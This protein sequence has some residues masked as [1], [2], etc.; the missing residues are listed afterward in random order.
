MTSINKNLWTFLVKSI[1]ETVGFGEPFFITSGLAGCHPHTWM[2]G[3]RGNR[4]IG[5]HR[6]AQRG[7]KNSSSRVLEGVNMFV[8]SVEFVSVIQSIYM[9]RNVKH[10]NPNYDQAN[11]RSLHPYTAFG[12]WN[13]ASWNSMTWELTER[14]HKTGGEY[15]PE[16]EWRLDSKWFFGK[17]WLLF[18]PAIFGISSS[19]FWG[20]VSIIP[21]FSRDIFIQMPGSKLL[22]SRSN[23]SY[24]KMIDP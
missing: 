19:N 5:I 20:V 4:D 14:L 10:L 18:N 13:L 2:E 3:F 23:H 6:P 16:I 7:S 1:S 15:Q 9:G 12:G 21:T 17:R 8:T 22:R 11:K 24:L